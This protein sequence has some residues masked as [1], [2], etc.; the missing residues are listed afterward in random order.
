MIDKLCPLSCLNYVPIR[1]NNSNNNNN[2]SGPTRDPSDFSDSAFSLS[3][4]R[5]A[6]DSM[7]DSS[8]P[9]LDQV[10]YKIIKALPDDYLI[11]LT[12]L[13][14]SLFREGVFPDQWSHSLIVLIPKPQGSGIR[15]ISLLSCFL[16][17]MEKVLY[18]RLL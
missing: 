15:P 12:E 10:S 16:K 8:A 3:E 2:S 4:V 6:L 14:N 17:L 7:K 18:G 9:G 13:Y 1:A 5:S 11:V